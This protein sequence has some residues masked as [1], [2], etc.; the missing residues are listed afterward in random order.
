MSDRIKRISLRLNLDNSG[1][2]QAWEHLRQADSSLPG[3][4]VKSFL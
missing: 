2:A 1:E 3:G 4:T